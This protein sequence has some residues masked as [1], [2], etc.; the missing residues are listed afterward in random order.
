MAQLGGIAAGHEQGEGG[1]LAAIDRAEFTGPAVAGDTLQ[2]NVRVVKTFGRLH[3]LEGEV[4]A[5][6]R[7]LAKAGLTLGVGK[8]S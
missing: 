1:F 2:V 4:F 5:A 6:G 7:L 8:L 3:M